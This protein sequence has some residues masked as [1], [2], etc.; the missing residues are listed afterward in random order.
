[1]KRK[2][3]KEKKNN[4]HVIGLQQLADTLGNNNSLA[5]RALAFPGV[6]ASP[7]GED[8]GEALAL[9]ASSPQLSLP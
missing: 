3:E 9:L 8:V 6:A 7:Q 5:L 4:I 2:S 1:M